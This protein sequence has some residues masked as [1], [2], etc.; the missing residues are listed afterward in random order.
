L[1]KIDDGLYGPRSPL[2]E[3]TAVD[4]LVEMNGVLAGD[5]ILEGGASLTASLSQNN[6]RVKI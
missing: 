3:R 1:G 6:V 4:E 2:F 5:D